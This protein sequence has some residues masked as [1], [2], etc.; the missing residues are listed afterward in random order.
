MPQALNP[1]WLTQ[2][3][4][5]PFP[6]SP[7]VIRNWHSPVWKSKVW[8]ISEQNWLKGLQMVQFECVKYRN[9][10]SSTIVWSSFYRFHFLVRHDASYPWMRAHTQTIGLSLHRFPLRIKVARFPP[11]RKC[12]LGFLRVRATSS[13]ETS[14]SLSL[15]ALTSSTSM[16]G[17]TTSTTP[18]TTT[19]RSTEIPPS[20]LPPLISPLV[21]FSNDA[22][23][24]VGFSLVRAKNSSLHGQRGNDF[25]NKIMNYD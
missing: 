25:I 3:G 18:S 9:P 12:E 21:S 7:G 4:R 11:K 19:I 13:Y 6:P 8:K 23:P 2:V 16:E 24:I 10:C 5:I 1:L 20:R 17:A 22:S 15:A 14:L